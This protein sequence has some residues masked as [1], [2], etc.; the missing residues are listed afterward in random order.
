MGE[1]SV[2]DR[3]LLNNKIPKNLIQD[4]VIKNFFFIKQ[5]VN[6]F[7]DYMDKS[8]EDLSDHLFT[9]ISNFN[10]SEF[11]EIELT[12]FVIEK[13]ESSDNKVE[14]FSKNFEK[15]SDLNEIYENLR[16]IIPKTKRIT[17]KMFKDTIL[18][19]LSNENQKSFL[20]DNSLVKNQLVCNFI[21]DYS[22]KSKDNLVDYLLN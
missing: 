12:K 10:I 4:E 16:S 18:L 19:A 20:Y 2:V 11:E 17:E 15:G 21:E 6:N 7:K 14:I 9:K 3:F 5:N 22:V 8:Y 1:S 13:I